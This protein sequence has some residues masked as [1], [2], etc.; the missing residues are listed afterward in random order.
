MRFMLDYLHGIINKEFS[1]A[2]GGGITGTPL[3][4]KVGGTMDALVLR[5]Q[6]AF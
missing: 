6:F 3:G 2:A 5:S 1:T 4:A